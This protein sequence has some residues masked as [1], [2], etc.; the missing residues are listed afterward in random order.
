ML[1]WIREKFGKI[2]I[3]AIVTFIAFVFVFYGVFSPRRTQGFHS[4][5]VAGIVNGDAITLSEF[6][7]ALDQRMNYFKALGGGKIT[8]E[9]MKAFRLREGVFQEL[10]SRRLML[11]EADRQG[12][13]ASDEEVRT[14]VREMPVFQRTVALIRCTIKKF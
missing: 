3:G 6:S 12:L 7:K 9:Q 11:Q 13:V 8:P 10:V 4:G 14:K 5:T 2:L 1:T